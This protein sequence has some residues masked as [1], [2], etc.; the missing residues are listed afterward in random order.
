MQARG[1]LVATVALALLA[2][3]VWFSNREEERK[4]E[5]PKA[6]AAPKS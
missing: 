5:A 3:G 1:L 2:A 6:D 4:A